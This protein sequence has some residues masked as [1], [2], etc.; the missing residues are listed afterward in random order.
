[1]L[2]MWKQAEH[3]L[4]GWAFSLHPSMSLLLPCSPKPWGHPSLSSC[5][6]LFLVSWCW[7]APTTSP[8]LLS[9]FLC[10]HQ[11]HHQSHTSLETRKHSW[12]SRVT[13][14]LFSNSSTIYNCNPLRC[15][16]SPPSQ[17][18]SPSSAI[19]SRRSW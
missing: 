4:Q 2:N 7:A 13:C 8:E 11:G 14:R 12:V 9:E 19:C 17:R 6:G 3:P 1:M 10:S 16:L 15:G 5:W 18:K